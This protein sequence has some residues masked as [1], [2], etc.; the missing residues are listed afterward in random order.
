VAAFLAAAVLL[1]GATTPVLAQGGRLDA[2][3]TAS[4]GGIPVGKGN[5]VVDINGTRYSASA[6][7]GTIGLLKLFASG[8]GTGS[9]RGNFAGSQPVVSY[10]SELK[11]ERK[12]DTVRLLVNGGTVKDVSVSPP[13]DPDPERV[14]VTEAHRRGVTDPMT[15]SLVRVPPSSAMMG[16]DA[17]R[18]A[19]V[20]DGRARFDLDLAYKRLDHVKADKGYDGPVVVCSVQFKPLAGFI[21]SRTAVKYLVRQRDMEVWLAPVAGTRVMVPFRVS[22]PTPIGLAVLEATDF[23]STVQAA[24]NEKGR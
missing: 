12:T 21:P 14:P 7:G 16:P 13:L 9:V 5:W 20:F 4:L 17:C 6:H 22:V 24:S 8:E 15:A 19:A 3:Y 11:T 10:S 1:A 2:N 18:N 23:V